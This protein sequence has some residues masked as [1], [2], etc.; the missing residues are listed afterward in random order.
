METHES[1]LE[2]EVFWKGHILKAR[3]FSGS[4][5]QYCSANGLSKGTF[6]V[7][8]KRLG[9]TRNT[10]ARQKAFVKVA[11]VRAEPQKGPKVPG[12]RLPDP[13]WVAE[14]ITALNRV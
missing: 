5:L 7:F 2:K 6:Y 10:K 12:N 14:L 13:K 8:K 1:S 4:D 11:P 3:E 9:F